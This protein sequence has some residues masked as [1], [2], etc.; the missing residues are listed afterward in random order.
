MVNDSFTIDAKLME[1]QARNPLCDW[2]VQAA[3]LIHSRL[4]SLTITLAN[5]PLTGDSGLALKQILLHLSAYKPR[6]LLA[7]MVCVRVAQFHLVHR[8]DEYHDKTTPPFPDSMHIKD[9]ISL[10]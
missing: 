8:P 3:F 6:S 9:F 10:P 1:N 7:D 4:C 2:V 5:A